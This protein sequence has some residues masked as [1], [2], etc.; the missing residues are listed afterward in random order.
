MFLAIDQFNQTH[1]LKTKH[2]RKELL[3]LFGRSKASKIYCDDKFG[4]SHHVGYVIDG[5]WL[6][7]YKVSEF[8]K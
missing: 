6:T 5:I 4:N 3:K 2:P 1:L 8:K 7:L